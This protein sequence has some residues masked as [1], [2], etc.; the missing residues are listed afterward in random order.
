MTHIRL[1]A[2][3]IGVALLAASPAFAAMGKDHMAMSKS[4]MAMMHK[5]Q[6]M[7]HDMMMKNK[8]CAAMMKAHPD[9]MSGGMMAH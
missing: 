8:R 5:C 9:M 6:A 1:T 2:A 3:A 7:S 4:Q